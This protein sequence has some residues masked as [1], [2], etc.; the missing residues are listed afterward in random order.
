MEENKVIS[1]EE[2]KKVEEQVA[3]KQAEELKKLSEAK[4]VEIENKVRKEIKDTQEKEQVISK[5]AQLEEANRKLQ[6]DME[7]RLKAERDAFEAKIAELE[8]KRKG[9]ADNDSPFKDAN[10]RN[11]IDVD[12]LDLKRV[13]EESRE[14]FKRY[15]GLPGDWGI[16][17]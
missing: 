7:S 11:G 8:A 4:A 12:K 3:A 17:R 15:H 5:L 1:D 9:I 13:E 6:S 14:A 2:I 10:I 16:K